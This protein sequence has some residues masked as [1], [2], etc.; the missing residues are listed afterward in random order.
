MR[1]VCK[2]KRTSEILLLETINSELA[3]LKNGYAP[4]TGLFTEMVPI[5][6]KEHSIMK[7]DDVYV[8][9][10]NLNKVK[11]ISDLIIKV[12]KLTSLGINGIATP[13]YDKQF[14]KVPIYFSKSGYQ[15]LFYS[16]DVTRQPIKD[17]TLYDKDGKDILYASSFGG[18]F[19]IDHKDL[20]LPK[21]SD[22]YYR[23][24]VTHNFDFDADKFPSKDEMDSIDF[25]VESFKEFALILNNLHDYF[26]HNK[27]KT[28]FDEPNQRYVDLNKVDSRT[29]STIRTNGIITRSQDDITN[30]YFIDIKDA[31]Y[32]IIANNTDPHFGG[33]ITNSINIIISKKWF[34]EFRNF[35]LYNKSIEEYSIRKVLSAI[36]NTEL[37]NSPLL[38]KTLIQPVLTK[39][40]K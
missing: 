21:T 24:L 22:T 36:E 32:T 26:M 18:N 10:N 29:Y 16:S 9:F 35:A 15:R 7:L 5:L 3:Q 11:S 1:E 14:Y 27:V 30:Q 6:K 25:E 31:D 2:E 17:M 33:S 20:L 38:A 13:I 23:V 12:E 39:T 37:D 28:I 8:F 34:N 19:I 40:L 4:S